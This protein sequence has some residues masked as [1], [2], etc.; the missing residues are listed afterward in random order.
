MKLKKTLILVF[1][2]LAAV[3]LGAMLASFTASIPFLSWLSFYKAIGINAAAPAVLDLSVLKISFGF[4][5]GINV[6][7]VILIAA[8]LVLYQKFF[9]G[10]KW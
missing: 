5:M 10:S 6:A 3:I 4:E 9:S 1:L 8:A 2:I 7:Q